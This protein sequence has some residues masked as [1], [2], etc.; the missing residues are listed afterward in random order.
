MTGML[1]Y[2]MRIFKI[3]ILNSKYEYAKGFNG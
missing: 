2:Q 3:K 1:D